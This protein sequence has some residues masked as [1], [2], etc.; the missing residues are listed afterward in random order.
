[1]DLVAQSRETHLEKP[2]DTAAWRRGKANNL[3]S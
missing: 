2:E 3:H 1:M